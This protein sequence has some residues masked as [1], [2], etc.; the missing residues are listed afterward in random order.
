M[1]KQ[2]ARIFKLKHW[3][4][5][6]QAIE[7]IFEGDLCLGTISN[8]ELYVRAFVSNKNNQLHIYYKC[9]IQNNLNQSFSK[10]Q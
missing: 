4:G 7:G 1:L 8:Q 5:M 2:F 3:L 9:P 10:R 6:V